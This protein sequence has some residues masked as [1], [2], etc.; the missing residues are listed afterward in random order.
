[1]RADGVHLSRRSVH[2]WRKE[3]LRLVPQSES[4]IADELQGNQRPGGLHGRHHHVCNRFTYSVA[5]SPLMFGSLKIPHQAIGVGF[6][7]E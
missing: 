6:V 1:V 7:A 5:D 4:S 3:K 2:E